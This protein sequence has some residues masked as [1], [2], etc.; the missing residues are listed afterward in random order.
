GP[1]EWGRG[2]RQPALG[3]GKIDTAAGEDDSDVA[4]DQQPYEGGYQ[5][6]AEVMRADADP[7]R[8]DNTGYQNVEQ[9]MPR[10]EAPKRG[11]ERHDGDRMARGKG[12]VIG[13][14]GEP[15]KIIGFGA[16][17]QFWPGAADADLDQVG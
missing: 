9:Q 3:G 7:A 13:A 5:R 16:E 12:P 1:G 11:H 8:R 10:P 14:P 6:V 15:A 2:A 4:R 17:Q